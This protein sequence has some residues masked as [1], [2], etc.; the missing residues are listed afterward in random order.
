MTL[1]EVG[2]SAAQ[3]GSELLALGYSVSEVVHAYGDLCQAVSD[4]AV[5]RN[6]PFETDEF[7]TLNR[8]LDNAIAEAVTEFCYQRDTVIEAAQL[9]EANKHAGIFIHEMRNA[10]QVASFAFD[11][12]KAERLSLSG[13][14]GSVLERSLVRLDHLIQRAVS[15]IR[16]G[17]GHSLPSRLFSAAELIAEVAQAGA[18]LAQTKQ[19]KL[20]VAGVDEMLAISGDRSNLYIAVNN[21][22]QNAF[23]FTRP[24]TEVTLDAYAAADRI[25]IDVKDHC[26]GL[27]HG[28]IERMFR[29]FTQ[30]GSDKSG[31]GLGL[32]ISR[33]AVVAAGGALSALDVPG[34][35]CVFTISLPRYKMPG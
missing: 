13:A 23:K 24:C 14:T 30:T 11:A 16:E 15:E 9:K 19:C 21:L 32:S 20:T 17:A 8:C 27:P 31:L 7:R 29:P 3:H 5:E 10:L 4:L 12:A 33:D 34:Q 25:L 6:I 1:S 35:G 22:V 2:T 18:L 28:S 26:G